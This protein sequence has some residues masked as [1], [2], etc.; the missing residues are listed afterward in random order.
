V[1]GTKRDAILCNVN[2]NKKLAT[3][4]DDLPVSGFT[5]CLLLVKSKDDLIRLGWQR[6][7]CHF[8]FLILALTPRGA[9]IRA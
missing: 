2:I 7:H 5:H 4:S 9:R 1:R 3:F 8:S 6:R